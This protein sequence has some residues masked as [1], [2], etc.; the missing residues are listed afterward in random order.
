GRSLRDVIRAEGALPLSRAVSIARQACSA[1]AAAHALGITHRDIKPDNILLARAPD[2][3]DLVK[4]LDFGIAKVKEGSFDTGEG[5]TPTQTGMVMGTPQYISP[6]QAMGKRGAE[7]DGRSDLYSLGVVLYEMVTGRLPFES[8]TAM[9]MILHHLQTTPTPPQIARADLSI[10]A[11][12]SELL[13][14]ALQKERDRRFASADE[15]LAALDAVAA[16]PLPATPIPPRRPERSRASP[17]PAPTPA[18]ADK[19]T[20]RPALTH[21]DDIEDR[22][23]RA[24][25]QR[26]PA[27]PLPPLPT[28]IPPLPRGEPTPVPSTAVPE[29]LWLALLLLPLRLVLLPLRFFRR[30]RRG[31]PPSPVTVVQRRR[32]LPWWLMGRWWFW[33]GFGLLASVLS[34]S[35]RDQRRRASREIETP[36]AV[37]GPAEP[38]AAP[39]APSGRHRG[40]APAASDEKLQGKVEAAL[41]SSKL[42]REEDVDVSVEDGLVTLSGH[43]SSSQAAEVAQALAG[44]VAGRDKVR[45]RLTVS[46]DN[47]GLPPMWPDLSGIPFLSP[48]APGTPQARALAELLQ[49]GKAA[50][51]D[52][53]PE[54][55]LGIFGAALNL[56][57]GNKAAHEGLAAAG[58]EM[59][60][61]HI[62]VPS[63]P[64]APTPPPS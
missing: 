10:P 27:T 30:R 18:P 62:P 29:A 26:T 35:N 6:E 14:R 33:V 9:G 57:P 7:V 52:G 5:Y 15:M 8:D 16:L 44:A 63:P 58:R 17:V 12:L 24:L 40:H 42:T 19:S 51:K 41:A 34:H 50:L 59:S 45:S 2:G 56:D 32:V 46:E 54:E 36:L 53:R 48:P 1:L 38:S 61:R 22:P 64:G 28:A 21:V 20:P 43:V 60:R 13:M 47:P 3:N 25:P 31:R 39:E 23:T 37:E 49:K 55:A 4:V 11:P